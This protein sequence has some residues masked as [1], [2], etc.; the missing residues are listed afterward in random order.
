MEYIEIFC[1]NIL[2]M[3]SCKESIWTKCER[4]TFLHTNR[5]VNACLH[6]RREQARLSE[7]QTV[8]KL[9]VT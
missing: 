6:L 4:R 3:K 7:L 2:N 1:R 9:H 5:I 8:Y